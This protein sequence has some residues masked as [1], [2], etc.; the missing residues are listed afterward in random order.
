MKLFSDLYLAKSLD[1][2]NK[3]VLI[4]YQSTLIEFTQTLYK[5]TRVGS[6]FISLTRHLS[7][8]ERKRREVDGVLRGPNVSL[9]IE[10]Q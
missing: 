9:L 1:N 3:I 5:L 8:D 7:T 10:S 4:V 2:F 6:S